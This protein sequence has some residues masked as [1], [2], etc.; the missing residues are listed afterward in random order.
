MLLGV[1]IMFLIGV[2][3]GIVLFKYHIA[4]PRDLKFVLDNCMHCVKMKKCQKI[5]ELKKKI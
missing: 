3:I 4:H 2:A 1:I 5:Q